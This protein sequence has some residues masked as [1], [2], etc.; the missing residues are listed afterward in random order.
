MHHDEL[1]QVYSDNGTPVA[2][3][4]AEPD[5]FKTDMSLN[6]G[7]SHIWFWKSDG[8]TTEIMLQ[9]RSL[10]KPN[11]PGWYHISAGGHINVG[12]T[13]VV[14]ATREVAEE[15]GYDVDPE[16]LYFVQAV[17][18]MGREPRDFVHVF[19]YRLKGDEEF[20]YVD[21]EVDSYEWRTVE[22]FKEITGD[23]ENNNLVPQGTLYFDTLIAALEFLAAKK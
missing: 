23:A 20:T 15:M 14:A 3:K 4:G 13:P 2:G 11:R 19:L 8:K 12:E 22:N 6:M 5:A 10:T 9:K 1:W 7:N 17:R 18:I 21:G 16:K